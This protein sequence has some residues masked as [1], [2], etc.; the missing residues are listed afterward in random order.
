MDNLVQPYLDAAKARRFQSADTHPFV[1][2]NGDSTNWG[3]KEPSVPTDLLLHS[4]QCSNDDESVQQL[5]LIDYHLSEVME[6]LRSYRDRLADKDR[7]DKIGKEW[8]AV[9]LVFDRIFFIIYLTTIVVSMC[10][11]LPIIT[12]SHVNRVDK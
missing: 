7:K 10:V 12:L 8:K 1:G 5:S 3:S 6:F 2:V 9:G 4:R 11:L